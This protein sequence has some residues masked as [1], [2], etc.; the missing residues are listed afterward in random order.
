HANPINAVERVAWK[1]KGKPIWG[2]KLKE[3]LREELAR[4]VM[5]ELETF[6]EFLATP[7]TYVDLDPEV[8]DRWGQPVA[9][10]TMAKH[11]LDNAAIKLLVDR[12][13]DV[14]RGMDPDEAEV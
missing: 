1:E 8:K 14:L 12:G 11:P 4:S 3:R 7:G 2:K 9:R 13:M 5:L 10:M 6:C